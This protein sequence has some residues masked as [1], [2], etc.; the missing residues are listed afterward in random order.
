MISSALNCAVEQRLI[1]AD[2]TKGCVLPKL[3]RKEIKIFPAES[4]SA[5]FEEAQRN[6]VFEL[7]HIDF[8]TGLR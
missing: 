8:A 6:G 7:Y 3:E 5:F 2:S 4:L 1:L